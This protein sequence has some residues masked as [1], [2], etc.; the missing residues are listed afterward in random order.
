VDRFNGVATLYVDGNQVASGAIRNDFANA[1]DMELARDTGGTF[2][3]LG[4]L[5]EAR[6]HSS[7]ESSNWVWASYMTVA[8]NTSWENYS[9]VGSPAVSLGIQISSGNVVLTWPQGT[10]QSAA[11]ITGPFNDMPGAASPYTN[12]VPGT[13]QYFRVRVR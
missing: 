3:F 8:A 9:A 5:D 10:L 1:S 13:R 7:L 11:Q 4:S 6:I 2:A 12:S